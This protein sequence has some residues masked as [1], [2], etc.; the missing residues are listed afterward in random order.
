MKWPSI[1]LK[2]S[3][4]K[5]SENFPQIYVMI[6]HVVSEDGDS[7]HLWIWIWDKIQVHRLRTCN[8]FRAKSGFCSTFYFASCITEPHQESPLPGTVA[9]LENK[10]RSERIQCC[11]PL[12]LQRFEG[13]GLLERF[14]NGANV[15][16]T[17]F[18][19]LTTERLEKL[20]NLFEKEKKLVPR[21]GM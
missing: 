4:C 1:K 16:G 10:V 20:F 7:N 9:I 11:V 15:D 6:K 12:P 14:L 13:Q 17:V 19:R 2:T 3:F 8:A 18:N 5:L 21:D